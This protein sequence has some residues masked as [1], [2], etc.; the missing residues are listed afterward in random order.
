MNLADREHDREE[1]K[2]RWRSAMGI[3]K[4]SRLRKT[5]MTASVVVIVVGILT[6]IGPN[7][8]LDDLSWYLASFE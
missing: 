8:L 1:A 7:H 5:L 4:P 6:A 2:K 3:R